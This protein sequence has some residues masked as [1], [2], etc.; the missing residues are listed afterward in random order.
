MFLNHPQHITYKYYI[1]L[2]SSS[3]RAFSTV[4]F[5]RVKFVTNQPCSITSGSQTCLFGCLRHI[6]IPEC[7]RSG[8]FRPRACALDIMTVAFLE[9]TMATP[10]FWFPF[11]I[12]TCAP[13]KF[14]V[15]CKQSS[16]L[17]CFNFNSF[18]LSFAHVVF[19]LKVSIN[20]HHF[21]QSKLCDHLLW[22]ERRKI[23]SRPNQGFCRSRGKNGGRKPKSETTGQHLYL[24][25][26]TESRVSQR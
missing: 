6:C 21:K 5:I 8:R 23:S 14:P 9:F 18:S 12:F 19:N 22:L 2:E 20:L 16:L 13:Y 17:L 4:V 15:E 11:V 3:F 25:M 1:S 24:E 7:N 26:E 10:Y